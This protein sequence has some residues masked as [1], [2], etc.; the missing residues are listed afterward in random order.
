MKRR[1]TAKGS[2]AAVLLPLVMAMAAPVAAEPAAESSVGASSSL[3]GEISTPATQAAAP[4]LESARQQAP[5]R[6]G[7]S[8]AGDRLQ[9]LVKGLKLD[10][11]QQAEV[12]RALQAQRE[13]IRRLTNAPADPE[14]P[15]V[16]AIHAITDR[17]AE[18]IRAVL[19]DEQKKLYSQPLPHDFA[20]GEGKPGVEEWL[21][22]LRPKGK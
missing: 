17:T 4:A 8:N 1:A 6:R 13:A 15:R 10:G 18:R 12:R 2:I 9:V 11:A 20:A 19:N 5:H 16:A 14:V 22:A 7:R 21:N 3:G